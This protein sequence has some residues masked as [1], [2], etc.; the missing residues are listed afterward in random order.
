[1]AK[2]KIEV[3]TAGCPVCDEAV[4]EIR[5]TAC[6]SCDIVVYNLNDDNKENREKAAQYGIKAVPSV[7]IDGTPAACCDNRGI[8]IETL[9]QAGLG[10][11]L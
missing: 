8:D 2:R 1:M 5:A 3:F 10:K 4:S 7:V 11:P 9:K 6:P